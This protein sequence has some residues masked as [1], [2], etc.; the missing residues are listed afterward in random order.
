[1]DGGNNN[2]LEKSNSLISKKFINS[3]II[4]SDPKIFFIN[5]FH[6]E[7][8]VNA[9]ICFQSKNIET[10]K[11]NIE[12][13]CESEIYPNY[14]PKIYCINF[15]KGSK[16]QKT[17]KLS[18]LFWS[19]NVYEI[20]ELNLKD[21]KNKFLK[22]LFN[23][24][25]IIDR[26]ATDFINFSI[27]KIN[28][29]FLLTKDTY[30]LPLSLEQKLDIYKNYLEEYFLY[31]KEKEIEYKEN[32]VS[33]FI[34][35]L[36]KKDIKEI[37]FSCLVKLLNL[38][39]E[40]KMLIKFLDLTEK[41][42]YIKND[43]KNDFIIQLINEYISNQND[44]FKPLI[45]IG[46]VF[47]FNRVDYERLLNDFILTYLLFYNQ[48]ILLKN[49]NFVL[50][51]E[52]VL[53][54]I[55]AEKEN[56]N[57][58]IKVLIEYFD[59]FYI[60]YIEKE[61]KYKSEKFIIKNNKNKKRIDS[62][63]FNIFRKYYKEL[64][65][66]QE[67]KK[68][69]IFDLTEIIEKYI[70][71]YKNQL[72]ILISIYEVCKN[73]LNS[74]DLLKDKLNNNIHETG[75]SLYKQ[76]KLKNEGILEFI[77]A[78][79]IY[80]SSKNIINDILWDN[81]ISGKNETYIY[82]K[83]VNIL[84]AIDISSKSDQILS[85]IKKDEIYKYF[86][87]RKGDYLKIF[88]QKISNIKNLGAFYILLPKQ[89]FD[90][91]TAVILKEWIL[92]NI[93]TISYQEKDEFNKEINI[94]LNILI[95]NA[96]EIVKG[97]IEQLID[98]LGDY[99][100]ELC[101]YFL[102][103]NNSLNKDIKTK[104]ISYY[105][106]EY[107]NNEEYKYDLS[108]IQIISYF[109]LHYQKEDPSTIK[110]FL[111]K[112]NTYALNEQDFFSIDKN[113][114]YSLFEIIVKHKKK[115]IKNKNGDYLETMKEVCSNI[116][117]KLKIARY[118]SSQIQF[119]F[120]ALKKEALIERIKM[121]LIFL[122]EFN[123]KI[124][125]I[126]E[127]SN[128]IYN[129]LNSKVTKFENDIKN[130]NQVQIFIDEFYPHVKE[131]KLLK[132]EIE[133][134][135]KDLLKETL[136]NI[137][138]SKEIVE[139]YNSYKNLIKEAFVNLERKRN[140]FLFQEIYRANKKQIKDNEIYLLEETNKNFFQAINIIQENLD[141][142][143]HNYF[144]KYFY[145]IGYND[146]SNLDNEIN[147]LINY[148]KIK[149][150]NDDKNK[151]LSS[152][153]L[154]VNK[155]SIINIIKGII[156]LNGFYQK[157]IEKTN[158]E[159]GEFNELN[160]YANELSQ[161]IPPNRI[162]L[163]MD[164]I[165]K[166]FSEISFDNND[167]N[168]KNKIL[169]FFK[170]LNNNREAFYFLKIQKLDGI[171]DLKEFFLNCDENELFLSDI[172][173]FIKVVRFLNNEI[174]PIK[175]S[176]ELIKTFIYG[177]LDEEKFGYYFNV[178]QKY[179]QIKNLF[180]KYLKKEKGVL[181][182]IKDIMNNSIFSINLNNEK[183][184]YE[185]KGDLYKINNINNQNKEKSESINSEKLDA[186]Y[187]NIFFSINIV[188]KDK[189]IQNFIIIYRELKN[190]KRSID[191]LFIVCGYPKHITILFKITNN[192][193]EC[194]YD[195][196]KYQ[197]EKLVSNF[198]N[199]YNN[200]FGILITQMI[201]YGELRMFYGR[202]LYLIY[203]YIKESNFCAI[204]NL[205]SCA[206]NG[207]INIFDDAFINLAQENINDDYA[208]VKMIEN[209]VKSIKILF[210]FNNKNIE[211]IY[212][213]NSIV[214]LEN[215]NIQNNI[216]KN[217][218]INYRG[219][220]FYGSVIEEYDIIQIFLKMTGSWPQ[221]S[222]I[223]ICNKDTLLIEIIS[224]IIRAIYCKTNCLFMIVI[225]EFFD[226][227]KKEKLIN[228]LKEK[229][230]KESQMMISCLIIFFN[231]KDNEFHQYIL[232]ID[233]I[234]SI[235][236]NF[237]PD[238][239]NN[240][241]SNITTCIIT[242]RMCGEGK[243][244]Y[245]NKQ[246]QNN[247][248]I[249]YLPIGGKMTKDDL[250]ERIKEAF[251]DKLNDSINYILH[252]DFGQTNEVEL[253]KD[254]LF[255][256]L[257]L[258]K[259]ELNERVIYLK[260]NVKIYIE[261][262][263]NFCAYIN[264]YK[265]LF[266]FKEISIENKY[267]LFLN[268]EVKLVSSIIKNY[269]NNE[270]LKSNIIL[271][272][273]EENFQIPEIECKDIIIK[274]LGID[275][276]NLYQINTF[277]K[278][279]YC[280]FLKFN[281]YLGFEPSILQENAPFMNMPP[282][283]A[284]NIRKLIISSLIKVTKYF[285]IG[286]YE[287]LIK[288]QNI[289][290]SI[291]KNESYQNDININNLLN[292]KIDSIT[293]D[294]IK[295]SLVVF[296][297]DGNSVTIITT[298]NEDEEE[299]KNLAKLYNSQ[300][301]EYQK[302]RYK[303][304][305]DE[306]NLNQISKL[307]NLKNLE[308]KNILNILLNFLDVNG[309]SEEKLK[310]II[311]P[312]VYTA[313]NFI[314]VVLILMRI[315]A[316]VP[317][318]MMGETGCGKTTL[319]EMAFKLI[320]KDNISIK[321]LNV[322]DGINDQDIIAFINQITKETKDEDE[323]FLSKKIIEFN[324]YS[325]LEKRQ[326][327][328]MK[329]NDEI[330]KEYR[331][332]IEK[333]QIWVFF[334]EINTCNSLD[335]LT[336]ILCKHSCRGK[337]LEK[338]FIFIAACNPYR[339]LI[340][341]KKMDSILFH[342]NSKKKR[343]V[344][345]VNPLPHSLM[346]FV[347]N[348]GNLKKDDEKKYIE[349]MTT[350]ALMSLF[351]DSYENINV[352]NIC[353]E[354]TNIIIDCISFS[355]NFMKENNDVSIV[356]LREVHR[357][358]LL[359]KFF[360][361]FIL[362]RNKND[363]KFNGNCFQLFDDEI[364]TFYK[365]K[366]EIFYY[367]C[368]INLSLFL[369]YYL[370]LPDKETRENFEKSINSKRYF[371]N[372]FLKIPDLE[373][374]YILNNFIIPKG[375]AKNKALKENLFSALYCI[376]NK[377]P[378]IICGKP[379]RSKTLCIQILQNSLRGKG[380]N[381]YLC[382][383]FPELIIHKIQGAL[384]TKTDDV[385]SVFE[386]ARNAQALS[387]DEMHLVLMD[388]M[389]L[390]ELSPNNPLKVT[391]F[392]LENENQKIPFI[393]ISNWGLDASKMNRVIY[394][395]VQEPDE[396][397]LIFTAKEIIKS[398]E[399]NNE[400]K[401]N[402]CSKYEYIFNYLSKAYY[403]FIEDKKSKNDENKFFH[404]L[405]DFYSL[406]K[407][408]II[409]IINN[410]N[411]E[412]NDNINNEKELL[413]ICV[414][415]IE[416]NFD[417]LENSVK[418][419]KSYFFE[420]FNNNL[421]YNNKEFELLKCLKESIYDTES[422]YLLMISESSLS[423]DI[424]T[425]MLEE[426]NNQVIS[427]NKD[428]KFDK[429]DKIK[430]A[431][432]KQIRT[433]IG[434]KFKF[435]EKNIYYCDDVLYKIKNQME[436][437][438]ILILK[439]LE[440]VYPSLYELFNRSFIDLQGVKFARLGS[441]KSL[442]L[443]ND[444]FKVI[445]LIDQKNIPKEDP[446][447][448]N[449]FEKHIISFTNI[450]SKDLIELAEQIY[451]ILQEIMLFNYD[452]SEK[453][454][455]LNLILNKKIKF[456]NNE[457]VRGLVYMATKKGYKEKKDIILFILNKIVPS[458]SEDLIII[459]HKLDFKTKYNFYYENI[460]NI[461]KSNYSYN[462]INF[463]QKTKENV[464]IIYT[465]SNINDNL[466][467]YKYEINNEFFK[468]SIKSNSLLE[469]KINEIESIND[470]DKS[471]INFIAEKE[472]NL[473]VIR[474]SEKDLIKLN[475]VY[476]SI[477]DL[478]FNLIY[479]NNEY[480]LKNANK[481]FIILIHLS[482][483]NNADSKGKNLNIIKTDNFISFLSPV[484][485]YFIDSIN[486]KYNNFLNIL[487]YSNEELLLNIIDKD[488]NILIKLNN[489]FRYFKYIL[490]NIPNNFEN[491][492]GE[493]N[494]FINKENNIH[495]SNSS[496]YK[497]EIIYNIHKSQEMQKLIK[498]GL[499]SLFKKEE[500]ILIKIIKN[501][502]INPEDNDFLD[503]LNI[504][505]N[506]RIEFYMLK[507]IYLFDQ[508]QIF[509]SFLS[510]KN[511]FDKN[512][513]EEEIENY[514]DNIY[515]N[516]TNQLYLNGINLNNKIETKILYGL[517]IPFLQNIIN[518]ILNFIKNKISQKYNEKENF[519]KKRLD[520]DIEIE[521]NKYK[522][523]IF[524]LNN[525]LKNEIYNY[526]FIVNIL[527][528]GNIEIIKD[529]FNDCFHIFLMRS[530]KLINNYDVLIELLD[531]IIQLR[532]KTRLNNNLNTDFCSEGKKINLEKTFLYLY[533]KEEKLK[534]NNENN[535]E[536]NIINENIN[537][538]NLYVDIFINVLNFIESYSQEI[539][540]ILEF[541]DFLNQDEKSNNIIK[542]L[543]NM[544]LENKTNMEESERSPNYSHINKISFFYII[545]NLLRYIQSN[546][547]KRDFLNMYEYYKKIK[548]Y[549]SNL[550]KLEKRF[551]LF[552]KEIFN[553]SLMIN[554]FEYFEKSDK[555]K[556]VNEYEK[557]IK[558]I[559]IDAELLLSNNYD[560]II[561][562]LKDINNSLKIIFGEYSDNYS[563]L[564]NLILLNRYKLISNLKFRKNLIQI[565]IPDNLKLSNIKLI[566]KSYSLISRILGKIEPKYVEAKEEELEKL[567]K[568]KI[569]NFIQNQGN[570]DFECKK[571]LNKEYPGLNEII[572]YYFEN[573]CKNYFEKI[574][575][576]NKNCQKISQK[577]CEGI[578]KIYL[579]EAVNFLKKNQNNQN[580]LN[581]LG[582]YFCIAYIKR[583]L[584]IY[585]DLMINQQ[586]QYL[587][588][589]D[590][591]NKILFDDNNVKI[592]KEIKYYTLKLLLSKKNNDFEKLI[593][594]YKDDKIFGFNEYF[595]E[596][597]LEKFDDFFF[598][599]FLPNFNDENDFN[600]FKNY[601]YNQINEKFIIAESD[602][603]TKFFNEFG[604]YDN[605]NDI[606]YSYLYFLF[607][608]SF[609]TK[610]KE[611]ECINKLISLFRK[612]SEEEK[613]INNLFNEK[614]FNF[615][616][617]PKLNILSNYQIGQKIISKFEILFFAFRFVFNILSDKNSKNFYYRLLTNNAYNTINNN[618]IPGKLCNSDILI[619]SFPIIKQNYYKDP[620]YGGYLCSCG[621]HYSI[622]S[623][624]FPNREFNCPMCG[625]II[626]GKNYNLH[627]KEG[628]RRIFFNLEYKNNY[629]NLNDS[630]K[631]IPFVLLED[632]E[633]EIKQRKNHLYKGL[634]QE[635][636]QF[637]LEKRTKIREINYITFRILN[638]ILHGF[639]FYA[640]IIGKLDDGYLNNNLI[641]GMTCFE[642][643]EKDWEIID[644]ELKKRQIPNIKIFI[645]AIF[646]KII[647]QMK[648]Q[649]LFER[650]IDLNN[651]EKEIDRIIEENINNKYS[652]NKYIKYNNLMLK[653]E[654]FSDK[655]IILENDIN[656][657]YI[658]N[659][660]PD[661]KYFSKTKLPDLSD[662]EK[663]FNSL[664]ENKDLY[665][666]INFVLDRNSNIKYLEDLPTINKLCNQ[667][668]NFCSYRFSREEAKEKF[669]K[670]EI[671]N[672]DKLIDDFIEIY[673]KLRP[674]IKKYE[675][676]D[677]KDKQGNLYFNDLGNEQKISNFCVDIG[678]FNYGM[679]LAAIYKQMI[680]WQNQ[681]INVVLNSKNRYHKNYSEL[682]KQEI[683]I[684]DC[685]END[686]IKFPLKQEVMDDIIIKNSY[687]KDFG[688]IYYNFN[689]IEEE[690][691]SNILPSIKRFYSNNDNNCLRYVI[692]QYEG[693][694]GNKSNI[695]SKFIEKYKA[696]ELNNDELKIIL[697]YKENYEKNE[698]KKITNF[699]FSLQILIDIILEKNYDKNHLISDII[700]YNNSDGNL[701]ILKSL[702]NKNRELFKVDSLIGV[703]N[704]FEIICWVK[705]KRYLINNYLMDLNETITKKFDT[706]YKNEKIEILNKK[707]LSIAIRRY[708]SR[709]LSGKRGENE[710]NEKNN[711]KY[712]LSNQ[713]LWDEIGIINNGKFSAELN[714]LFDEDGS[715][716]KVCVGQAT[717]LYEFLAG[718]KNLINEYYNKIGKNKEDKIDNK[719]MFDLN[720]LPQNEIMEDE[721]EKEYEKID[722]NE[723][724]YEE[725]D[726]FDY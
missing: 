460:I 630:H 439:D 183:N 598:F 538:E 205:I 324:S 170:E 723:M 421:E 527:K 428:I 430:R 396:N 704:L 441:S 356:S 110:I 275:K 156:I 610:E 241:N 648:R 26:Q 107:K 475:D 126:D 333:R 193:I 65:D 155:Q 715:P 679:V 436:T 507:L 542:I 448:L 254:F 251:P 143:Q 531:I 400:K 66:L 348:F 548:I 2:N 574:K 271:E 102:N 385:I 243:S 250:I 637:F 237:F 700:D 343:L 570:P 484:K 583:Y 89:Y 64:A 390:A 478:T 132:E 499:A 521:K 684:Q 578:S 244:N 701:D 653:I 414:R 695:I 687:Q 12:Y 5:S 508:N 690:L 504:Y 435:D 581:I 260:S 559:I 629:E 714:I 691:A 721:N 500:D 147:W 123:F 615:I 226:L 592:F 412:E 470:F 24:I 203:S 55:Y 71:F 476:N 365:N 249:I 417:G 621:Y 601:F 100:V 697:D 457:E 540:N 613:C 466:L 703:F 397:D 551:L 341:E 477:N 137:S 560:L 207:L 498:R 289:T 590:D 239:Q 139:K 75:I 622:G 577:L 221:N 300:N 166:L 359:F 217:N 62:N 187:Q 713:Q 38:S 252:I 79:E 27:S 516:N 39:Y 116:I 337:P 84:T 312:Y 225:K 178:I 345:S 125:N 1:M 726:D 284:L 668:I 258:H 392:E 351:S 45:E 513:I 168:Y 131:K 29:N 580:T 69:Y 301:I 367:K 101:M 368:S 228:F 440:I 80:K 585:V 321:K 634:K 352:K 554:I 330:F 449:R 357:F 467:D 628:H 150:S 327:F 299:F 268:S 86:L 32:L 432:K 453:I 635:S 640:N 575:S 90:Y 273:L 491:Y 683:M 315:R 353:K 518:D 602:L 473:C 677:F 115:I 482:R 295:P 369:C 510:N 214:V 450:L 438:N 534:N 288:S 423:K 497:S 588:K 162:Q 424:L 108:N 211:D 618:M 371:E 322:H 576:K 676:H 708:V 696:R 639:L 220:Y 106:I 176:F 222:N 406:I 619:N 571:M 263:N 682:F 408:V 361:E 109:I 650:D 59:I 15:P 349:S 394:I 30:L 545:E 539:Y 642:I 427:E 83:D 533:R 4:N 495:D 303:G 7:I 722:D 496:K 264:T 216:N 645:N 665:P 259:C 446:P 698:D 262:A 669:I 706:S 6:N 404:G 277:I 522:E 716:A 564:M 398:Y 31:D 662:F 594:Y 426:I 607:Y 514:I 627:L 52:N 693:F 544:I 17:I 22:F 399:E 599:A 593:N 113:I 95:K 565:I 712:Y 141:E 505:L 266:F 23:D 121:I 9:N 232:K 140:S 644:Q 557:L 573:T 182:T 463:I 67:K 625:Q 51:C 13:T 641:G 481:I 558:K 160:N 528:S 219:F 56:Y 707:N 161:D 347:F 298:C 374:D 589:K 334:D 319:I 725:P 224:F 654:Q 210:S 442:S 310:N 373:M 33:D 360:I 692:Y 656:N 320:N 246:K 485:H 257:I 524:E 603:K 480:N 34:Y 381:S 164:E 157:N 133:Q 416:R 274:Y 198:K 174:N 517:K 124:K 91:E 461:Y 479:L 14:K 694:R 486:N 146:E 270:I 657:T 172:D 185:I 556:V 227:N 363:E 340:K 490:V 705:I 119:F 660:Y 311:G 471:I 563:E 631:Y 375:I 702:F 242:S 380:S 292:I 181:T 384:N 529:L 77:I 667:V 96:I 536:E 54:R 579:E 647:L 672:Q 236:T 623:F 191:M 247:E 681:F 302:L 633:N 646:D 616:I 561:N 643:M 285:T 40:N 278:V 549:L 391:H 487:N 483:A 212:K 389:G 419:F 35:A 409:D 165:R 197:L 443:V 93:N 434:S 296:N 488:N 88:T 711:L 158:E 350:V 238:N 313:D 209:I 344:Y 104:L 445:V 411:L 267:Q 410:K 569:L 149:I 286:P 596:I 614:N 724:N 171:K 464:S 256:L 103:N 99:Y 709:F 454:N 663:E 8:L 179:N 36:S 92:K 163:I 68:K 620:G 472:L 685:N 413:N 562:D 671:K 342:K 142:I 597:D 290:K 215:K 309:L 167:E 383:S 81:F 44:V 468:E 587:G 566:E 425:Y 85:N 688:L 240:N 388:E 19:S 670:N 76:G 664:E 49:K 72:S 233:N 159:K 129:N 465:F 493:D 144:L 377:I 18:I 269:E 180:D 201:S 294:K 229:A 515:N 501:S 636:K 431:R 632:L 659:E 28:N 204:K 717:K 253:V 151:F 530:N 506:Q 335:L 82:K 118:I 152:L 338:R 189:S 462:L 148:K 70:I 153:K 537:N 122:S 63:N 188:E 60:I 307:K 16:I 117:E 279:L 328:K 97:F 231:L 402:Y 572:L 638:F 98:N 346:N 138:N 213:N 699:L 184:I 582:K 245:I 199:I 584:E 606:I 325:E 206:T 418:E 336:E 339:L 87:D 526:Q 456:I 47:N 20:N 42:T 280:E 50:N 218:I 316:G 261:L 276:P 255:K 354:L 94:F 114:N 272:R 128:M 376:I 154:L 437:E 200:C 265:I 661:M 196:Q 609:L 532:L 10:E 173:E 675:Y 382:K 407:T 547:K 366:S 489:T 651:F 624:T 503:T 130:L 318:I 61:S 57:E 145:E 502:I 248:E 73:E 305:N 208:Y 541:F 509:V 223:L 105:L 230:K 297:N 543:K 282:E 447:F 112:I 192:K 332:E 127:E 586:Y 666:I 134:F 452:S 317:V 553:F 512:V 291:M 78:D 674:I 525:I 323:S 678:E 600:T 202:Q 689:L 304:I 444:N 387:K 655:S 611:N 177:I 53:K 519:K 370:R 186:L 720:E 680:N 25:K 234:Y 283:E 175:N 612:N 41:V 386:K 552:S 403:R 48:E 494:S 111:D 658:Y 673:K 474:F 469:I 293:Y 58:T 718:D 3:Q 719:N 395:V 555:E 451:L 287:N 37:Y 626:G 43:F 169:P 492:L 535:L 422:R 429:E 331:K 415:N 355:Q 550:F 379:G 568:E 326:Y 401:G 511:I 458:F 11:I 372:N 362:N 420:L 567:K 455:K 378:L 608:K 459:M 358:L 194:Y 405:R 120:K 393:G 686:L 308:H 74:N 520:E 433:F 329:S 604:K 136:E 195:S 546:F 649:K 281:N 652:I 595:K 306:N 135:K 710:I 617:L 314:K 523:E 605:K 21:D 591:I 46:K 364:V 235:N 190:L